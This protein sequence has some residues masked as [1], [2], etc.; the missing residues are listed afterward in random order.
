MR[1][2]MHWYPSYYWRKVR[3]ELAAPRCWPVG[4]VVA[5]VGSGE[6]RARTLCCGVLQ[7][8]P[9]GWSSLLGISFTFPLGLSWISLLSRFLIYHLEQLSLSIKV[10]TQLSLSTTVS[11]QSSW[12]FFLISTVF[13]LISKFYPL[14]W[15]PF[16]IPCSVSALSWRSPLNVQP[17]PHTL[18]PQW[19]RLSIDRVWI[20]CFLE[21]LI[22]LWGPAGTCYSDPIPHSRHNLAVHCTSPSTLPSS[23]SYRSELCQSTAGLLET[24]PMSGHRCFDSTFRLHYYCYCRPLR[25]K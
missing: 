22:G 16:S 23:S 15:W 8:A 19:S 12:V 6:R 25:L 13:Y 11:C 2:A 24:S 4:A 10:S 17:P 1:F 3:V 9:Q 14:I 5:A 7:R 20:C 21:E 18:S